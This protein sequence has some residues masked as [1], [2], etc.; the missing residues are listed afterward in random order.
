M[1][2]SNIRKK[3]REIRDR[4]ISAILLRDVENKKKPIIIKQNH[5]I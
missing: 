5:S 3:R 2:D 4:M 1:A